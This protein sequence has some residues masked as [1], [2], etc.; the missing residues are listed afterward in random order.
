MKTKVIMFFCGVCLIVFK[1]SLF[2]LNAFLN[3]FFDHVF[4]GVLLC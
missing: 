2:K 4:R 3:G 1:P